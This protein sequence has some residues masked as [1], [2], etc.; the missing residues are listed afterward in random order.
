[1]HARFETGDRNDFG[2]TT[3]RISSTQSQEDHM[4]DL[5]AR[6]IAAHGGLERWNTFNKVTATVVAGGGLKP[7]KGLEDDHNP[8]ERTVTLHEENTFISSVLQPG[9]RLA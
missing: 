8:R 2:E 9:W 3:W 6:A 1:M 5:L 7:M 4:N